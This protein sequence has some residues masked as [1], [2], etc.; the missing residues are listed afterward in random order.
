MS[1]C[2]I[3]L[4]NASSDAGTDPRFVARTRTGYVRFHN[5]QYYPGL[6]LFASQRCVPEPFEIEEPER[7]EHL[8]EMMLV[9]QAV[10]RAFGAR[11]MNYECL[12]NASAHV[13]W[14]LIP[15]PHDD[16]RPRGPVWENLDFLESLWTGGD[17][18]DLAGPRGVLLVELNAVGVYQQPVVSES[19]T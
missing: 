17:R 6:T 1:D 10:A 7:T 5:N 2:A 13:H 4:D 8:R 3:C 19:D 11:K 12:G 16:P 9:G 14:W 15:R 18:I